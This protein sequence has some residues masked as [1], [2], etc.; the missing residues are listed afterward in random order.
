VAAASSSGDA[1]DAPG[2]SGAG[3]AALLPV[4]KRAFANF[5]AHEMTDYAGTLTYFAMMALFPGSCSA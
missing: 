2:D 4:L 5:R 1:H 3:R